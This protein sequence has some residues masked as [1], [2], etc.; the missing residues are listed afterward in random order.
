MRWK[1]KFWPSGEIGAEPEVQLPV[2][3]PVI[4]PVGPCVAHRPEGTRPTPS[5]YWRRVLREQDIL[6]STILP[7]SAYERPAKPY[8]SSSK[9]STPRS[10]RTIGRGERWLAFVELGKVN[11]LVVSPERKLLPG[12]VL[13]VRFYDVRVLFSKA[14]VQPRPMSVDVVYMMSFSRSGET[15]LQRHLSQCGGLAVGYNLMAIDNRNENRLN[16]FL[17]DNNPATL[18]DHVAKRLAVTSPKVVAKAIWPSPAQR[19][20]FILCRHPVAI[21]SSIA[22]NHREDRAEERSRKLARICGYVHP[23]YATALATESSLDMV[24]LR[25]AQAWSHRMRVAFHSGVPIVHYER[26][27]LDH[28]SVLRRLCTHLGVD[29]TKRVIDAHEE[30]EAGEIGHGRFDLSS[31]VDPG[32]AFSKAKYLTERQRQIVNYICA[33][34]MDLYGYTEKTDNQLVDDLCADRFAR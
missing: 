27:V 19:R 30:F 4:R 14:Q 29:C 9:N 8:P 7:A 24:A 26:F 25:V 22:S 32:R 13:G 10:F 34:T 3:P 18:P 33:E 5:S 20:G 28:P 2:Y 31:S 16:A 11:R 23:Q 17:R 1:R 21:I 6:A 12:L 15:L